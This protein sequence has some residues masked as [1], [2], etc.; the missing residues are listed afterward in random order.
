M[1]QIYIITLVLA[2]ILL[3]GSTILGL[4]KYKLFTKKEKWYIYYIIFLFCIEL[5]SNILLLKIKSN[6][7]L[8]PVYIAG[9]F[10]IV[11]GI[12]FKKLHLSKYYYFITASLSLFF[13]TGD[14]ILTQYN[15]DYSKAISNIIIISLIGYSLIKDIAKIEIKSP[16]QTI[17]KMMFLYFTVS[18]F[19]FVFKLQLLEFPVDYFSIFWI[20]NNLLCIVLYSLFVYTITKRK[21]TFDLDNNIQL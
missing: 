1:L 7:S 20:T 12:F 14:R 15:N 3:T 8:Y 9:E 17:D 11:T 19:I 18:I 6:D 5:T 21:K 10:F 2:G 16:F 4:L 13:L